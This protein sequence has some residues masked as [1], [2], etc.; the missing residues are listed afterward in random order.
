MPVLFIVRILSI[1]FI[2]VGI[3]SIHVRLR[4][5]P[6]AT[7][8][9]SLRDRVE[10][11][12]NDVT[13]ATWSTGELD[14]AITQALDAYTLHL[15]RKAIGS[16]TLSAAGREIS[17]ASIT[18]T[19]ILH[20]WWDYDSTDPDY[21]PKFRNFSVWPGSL[22][23]INDIE[24]PAAGDVVR[25]WYT[26]VHTLNGLLS[27][28]VTTVPPAHDTIIAEGAAAFAVMQHRPYVAMAVNDNEWAPRNLKEWAEARLTDFYRD[29]DTLARQ[30]A[31]RQ[32]GLASGPALDRWDGSNTW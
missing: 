24:E 26:T 23:H 31:A 1:M 22:L 32:A 16:I 8:L 20:V 3:L 18:Y 14:E 13:N 21:P 5:P 12:L 29:L 19:D 9:A 28:T 27:A 10:L 17:L 4:R 6:M 11:Q 7:T 30:E 15:P 25:I 2:H